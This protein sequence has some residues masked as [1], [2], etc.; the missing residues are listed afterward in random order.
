MSS[1]E[2]VGIKLSADSMT[3]FQQALKYEHTNLNNTS[4]EVLRWGAFYYAR[5]ARKATK[6]ARKNV[7]RKL[8]PIM[9][10]NSY[11]KWQKN[12]AVMVHKQRRS[13]RN[14]VLLGSWG[15]TKGEAKKLRFASVPNVEASKN[16][17]YGAL[18]SVNKGIG[19]NKKVGRV[20]NAEY[21]RSESLH[22]MTITNRLDYL[23]KI[24][25][26]LESIGLANAA[27]GIALRVE[28]NIGKRW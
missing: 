22:K 26:D 7:K 15:M 14:V 20:S 23:L 9:S 3:A 16:S 11:G 21:V 12:W 10:Q 1:K 6:K 18:K 2:P 8:S 24:N 13:S 28:R 5:S 17:W 27:K 19:E 25:P 4:E